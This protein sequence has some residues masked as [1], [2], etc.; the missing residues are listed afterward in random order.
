MS[1]LFCCVYN[2]KAVTA[3]FETL[4]YFQ[5]AAVLYFQNSIVYLHVLTMFN[6]FSMHGYKQNKKKRYGVYEIK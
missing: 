5:S 2:Q 6:I 1:L 3:Y 4:F